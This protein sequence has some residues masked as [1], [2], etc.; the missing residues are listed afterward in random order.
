[1][2]TG[3]PSGRSFARFDAFGMY[4][5]LTAGGCQ[6]AIV[7]CTR[8]ATSARAWAVN[9]T[10]PSIPAVLRPALRCVTCR[11]LTSVFD[12]E[13][14]NSFCRLLT[15]GQ[16]PSCVALKIRCRSRRTSRSQPDQSTQSQSTASRPGS[17]GGSSGPF[18]TEW[19]LT[20]ASVPAVPAGRLHRLTC[21]C[22]RAFAPGRS[23]PGIRPVMR[24]DQWRV[25]DLISVSCRLSAAGIRFLGILSRQ[26]NWSIV[27]SGLPPRCMA[28][29][30][31]TGFPRSAR[32]RN[33]WGW[34][35]PVP[36]GRWCPHGRTPSLAATRRLPT[37]GP[38]H[39]GP[40]HRPRMHT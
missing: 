10:S 36:R 14:N 31:L 8:T 24:D 39:P 33:D 1:M 17:G 16:S 7:E 20:C 18:T 38:Y 4:T 35:P 12:R 37:A 26:W 2:I 25:I 6:V 19:R 29:R 23:P 30:T 40:A 13:R 9:A 15:R 34:V 27:T 5:R 21:P 3:I 22:G 11:T 28:W 32:M